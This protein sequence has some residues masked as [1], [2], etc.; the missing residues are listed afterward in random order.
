MNIYTKQQAYATFRFGPQYP[1]AYP[2]MRFP[3]SAID[4]YAP[5]WVLTYRDAEENDKITN[6]II[7]AIDAVDGPVIVMTHSQSGPRAWRP[8]SRAR[9]RSKPTSRSSRGFA[10]TSGYTAATLK[11]V[12]IFCVF[13]DNVELSGAATSWINA[14]RTVADQVNAAGGNATVLELPTIGIEGNS[15]MMMMDNNNEKI[16]DIIEEW[17]KETVKDKP[18]PAR[19]H[20]HHH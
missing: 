10:I 12:P 9:T 16:A 6:G 1:D 2:G 15:H 17:I 4:Q 3:L 18:R 13:G 19:H 20:G 14:A 7:A 8:C 11:D 5:Q